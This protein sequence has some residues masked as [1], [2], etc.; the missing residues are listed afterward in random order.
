[1]QL[2]WTPRFETF[3]RER[4][5]R[6]GDAAHDLEHIRRVVANAQRL[7]EIEG[8][9]MEIVLPAAW[10]H[11]CVS[12]PKHSPERALASRLAADAAGAFLRDAG[13]PVELIPEIEHAIHAHS[14]SAGVAPETPEAKVVQDADRLDALGA[15]GIA[16]TLMLGGAMGLP[17]YDADEPIPVARTPDDRR[18]VIDHFYVKLLR[19]AGTMQT[20]AGRAEAEARTASM[21]RFLDELRREL[22]G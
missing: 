11:D 2:T 14:F 22:G 12:V 3:V 6:H 19:L 15:V 9:R 1:M 8:A 10:L 13:Y 16:R 5:Q 21:Q 7:A 18:N 20:P 4:L 17:L